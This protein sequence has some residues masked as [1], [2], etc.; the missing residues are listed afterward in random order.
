MTRKKYKPSKQCDSHL[1]LSELES[2]LGL[3]FRNRHLLQQAL[4][5]GSAS[6]ENFQTLEFLGD[7]VLNLVVS[8]LLY[9]CGD[10]S[11]EGELSSRRSAVVNNRHALCS[12][13]EEF[14]LIEFATLD[15]SFQLSNRS[16]TRR[17]SA[18]LLEA[19]IGAV[20]L[21]GG[22]DQA[23]KFVSTHFSNLLAEVRNQYS[24]DSKSALQEYSH[25]EGIDLPEYIVVDVSGSSHE[26]IFTVECVIAGLDIPVRAQGRTVKEAEQKSAALAYESLCY[27]E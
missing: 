20:Y 19:V 7:A 1:R 27:A 21:D 15:R 9:R 24:K 13:S 18:D 5:H 2:L 14:R 25:T 3:R 11:S 10:Y 12:I 8:D 17:L 6:E 22:Y 16:A 4:T 26:P 23:V